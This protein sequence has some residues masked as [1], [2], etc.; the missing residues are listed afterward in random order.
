MDFMISH[1]CDEQNHQPLY[2]TRRQSISDSKNG[3]T[4]LSSSLPTNDECSDSDTENRLPPETELGNIEYKAK[5][6]NPTTSRIQHLITQMKWRLR[7]GQG[8]A[9]YEIGVEDGGIMSGLTDEELNDSLRTLRTMAQALGASMVILTEK[10]VTVKGSNSRRTVVEVLVRKVPE[11]QQFIEVRLAV[12]GGCD[13]GKSTLCGVLTQGCLDDGNGKAR[14]GIF[15]FPHEVRT[16]KTS[17]VCNDVIGFDNRGKLVNY[18]QNSLE[19]MVEKSSKLVTLID[20]AGDA[21]YQ[22]TTIHGLTGY[23][24]HFACLV[25]AADRGITWATREHLGLIAALNIPMFVLIT[26]M[27]L[28]DRQGLKKIIKD[29]SNLVAKAG[30]TAR[31]KRVKTKRDA[32]KA[33]QE[34]CVGSIVPVL[35]VSSV[36]GEGF[37]CLRTLLNCLST[38]GT[39]ESR[40]QLVGLPAFFTIEELYNVPH[41]GQVVGGMLSEGQLHEGADVLVGPMK[42]GT[43]EKITVGSIRRSRQAVGCVNPGEAASISLNLPDGVSLRRG[44]VL[45]EIDHQPPVCYEFTANLLL[46]CHSTKYICEGFQAT[47]FIG[48]VCTTA[49]ITHIDDADCIRPGKWAVVKMC[50]AYQPE[51]IREGSPI[52]LRQGKTKGMGEVLKVFPCTQ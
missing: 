22:K 27:D 47:V 3:P 31:E 4:L 13:V 25:V 37:R 23:T 49:I 33:A 14:I 26:K 34:L 50:F 36:S 15:R 39:A 5:L 30:M 11:S 2:K 16:G 6:V 46:L 42:D 40:I 28:V 20:L 32:V 44:M 7:E 18:A 52:I 45:A 8:E 12:V 51:V 35:A 41:V 1:F 29:V 43:F 24:P 19:E 9:I 17:S 48:S 21:K 38:A 10:D